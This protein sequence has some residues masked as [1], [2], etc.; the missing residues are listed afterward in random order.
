[1]RLNISSIQGRKGAFFQ[2]KRQIPADFVETLPEVGQ[3]FGPISAE[4][5]VTNTGEAYLVTG[6]L[7]LDVE[8]QCSRCLKPLQTKVE[9][10]IEEEFYQHPHEVEEE[11]PFDDDLVVDGDELDAT[12]LIEESI[13][14]SIPMKPICSPDCPGLCSTCGADL[15]EGDCE[16]DNTDIDLRLAPLKELLKTTT[17]ER[18]DDHGSTKKKAFKSKD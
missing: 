4:L 18:R 9:A 2:V 17:P 11:L 5:T 13:L 10:S 1:M 16:C 6:E 15:A 8:L 12:S 14:I 7:S 3:V